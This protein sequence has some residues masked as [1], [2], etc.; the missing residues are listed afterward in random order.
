[1]GLLYLRKVVL[2]KK[3]GFFKGILNFIGL[4]LQTIL[5]FGLSFGPFIKAGG[6]DQLTQMASRLFPFQRGLVHS[7][8]AANFWAGF[9][10][11]NKYIM[12]I[13]RYLRYGGELK[14]AYEVDQETNLEQ[15]KMWC[16]VGT[17][18]FLVVSFP[19]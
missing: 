18:I 11:F 14:I 12:N 9:V 3:V 6:V 4:G 13:Y 2:N 7:Y 17:L 16:L 10:A 15:V 19:A 1:M 8:W 5:I